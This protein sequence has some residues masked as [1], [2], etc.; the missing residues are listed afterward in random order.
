M[1]DEYMEV[2]S[3]E[4]RRKPLSQV[5]SLPSLDDDFLQHVMPYLKPM[6]K[7]ERDLSIKFERT[8]TDVI[9]ARGI[10]PRKEVS[11]KLRSL[12]QSELEGQLGIS[13]PYK[14]DQ[15][16]KR[17]EQ[18]TQEMADDAREREKLK[19]KVDYKIFLEVIKEYRL[20]TEQETK[21]LAAIRV[22]A[23][24]EEFTCS[25]PTFVMIGLTLLELVMFAYTSI[26][27]SQSETEPQPISWTGPVPYC[28][29]LIF[30][31]RRRWE[32]WRFISYMFVHIGIGHFFFN[33]L[34]QII[35]GVFLEMEQE[36]WLGSLKVL[37]VYLAGVLAGSLGTSLSD[38]DTYIAGASG[39][40]YALIAAHLATMTLN[41]AED[42]QIRI[43]KVVKKPITKMIR[44]A[45][46]GILTLHDIV[47]AIYVRLYDP[48]N[49]TGFMGHLCG[50]LAGLTVGLFVLDNRRVR[51]WEPVVQWFA[52]FV[53]VACVSFAIVWNIFGDSWSSGDKGFF[54]PND[55]SLYDVG[56]CSKF[57]FM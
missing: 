51:S 25:P 47:F 7:D 48:E 27:M 42:S 36:G 11:Q 2:N 35:V 13:S 14:V 4:Y 8:G 45:F 50:A 21:V 32:W 15:I 22:F 17:A 55:D 6:P 20:N 10:F 40:V 33:M 28:S 41:W 53:F 18:K 46:I 3:K 24:V 43:Q 54:P 23:F 12:R 57:Q 19:G 44:I 49:R 37:T 52:L 1:G 56:A 26:A 29:H 5:Y 30:N 38:P 34:M 31:P 39:G 9:D 16:L